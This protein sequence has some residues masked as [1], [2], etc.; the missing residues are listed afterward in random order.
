[1][2]LVKIHIGKEDN[3]IRNHERTLGVIVHNSVEPFTL[4]VL[5]YC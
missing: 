2:D 5:Q 1:M 4:V 3:R